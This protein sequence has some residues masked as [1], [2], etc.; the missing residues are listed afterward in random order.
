MAT[1]N[2]TVTA[3]G[4]SYY[5]WNGHGLVDAQN[6]DL[7][8]RAGDTV[9]ITKGSGHAAHH[10]MR[11]TNN[12]APS[13][14]I[15]NESGG[16]IFVDPVVEGTYTY[17]CTSHPSAMRGA[18]TVSAAYANEGPEDG[19]GTGP[20]I[21]HDDGPL[22]MNEIRTKINEIISKGGVGGTP[23]T[24]GG[25]ISVS[26]DAP[27]SPSDG[28]LWWDSDTASLYVYF[29]DRS[30][31]IQ[32]NGAVGS[33]GN[34]STGWVNTDGT[35]AVANG[36]TL[37]FN[38]NLGTT[39]LV[40]DI[41]VSSSADGSNPQDFQ[42]GHATGSSN[43]YGGGVT[44]ITENILEI[45]L[46]SSGYLDLNSSGLVTTTSF[47]GKYI[48]VIASAKMG[49]GGGGG[50][51]AGSNGELQFNDNGAFGAA[52]DLKY[53]GG[54]LTTPSLIVG[55]DNATSGDEGGEIALA[56]APN[57]TIAG[58]PRIDVYKNK[59]RFWEGG[60]PYKGA[61]IDLT[62]CTDNAQT[63]LLAGGSGGASVTT[64]PDVPA[65]ASDGDL[66]YDESSAALY[67]YTDSIDGWVQANG[68]GGGGTGPRAYVAFDGTSSNL[69]SSIT[70]NFNVSSITD[71]GTGIYTI[72]FT[73]PVINPVVNA[74][75]LN[76][77]LNISND[78]HAHTR[79]SSVSSSAVV[80]RINGTDSGG[81]LGSYSDSNYVSLIVH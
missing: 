44:N 8:F 30:A 51:P 77:N 36:A 35:T 15:I 14:G 49:S 68:G 21:G 26:K 9:T 74:H 6:P 58:Y 39:D 71:G 40:V 50:T 1:Y 11:I 60:P 17:F 67:V 76:P 31:W 2:Y 18:I 46:S 33:G 28:D 52:Q 80:I 48:K 32:T 38:H 61:Y 73:S 23:G 37:T 41:Y 25:S 65:S 43:A 5:L 4:N 3:S 27:G 12:A 57:G 63:N 56:S 55:T 54:S 16:V 34:F 22:S 79:I 7:F 45:Q 62:E 24:G 69:T 78:N 81:N 29:A 72:T 10:L 47:S 64:S 13:V 20:L 19:Y 59:I 75:S 53:E 66:W 70:N 42:R